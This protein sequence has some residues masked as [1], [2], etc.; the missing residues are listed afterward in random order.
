MSVAASPPPL[1]LEE[2]DTVNI[3]GRRWPRA[4]GAERIAWLILFVGL[5]TTLSLARHLTPDPRGIGT[6]EQIPL[7][8]GFLPP[9]GFV[10]WSE[11]TFGKAYPCPS[12][13][14]TTTFTLAMHAQPWAAFKNQPFGFLVFCLFVTLVPV[15]FSC[16]ALSISPLRATDHWRWRWIFLIGGALWVAG[17][18]YKIR[19][20]TTA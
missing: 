5:V 3:L 18:L 11:Q 20:M 15:A 8:G 10:V 7:I 9:C 14:F 6:H 19:M 16:F 2:L 1:T 4:S 13:G 17:W 12:C